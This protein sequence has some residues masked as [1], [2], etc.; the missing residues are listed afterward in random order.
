MNN[1]KLSQIK[2]TL[3]LELEEERKKVNNLIMRE[4]K[5]AH[6]EWETLMKVAHDDILK[7]E[8]HSNEECLA[9]DE[10]VETLRREV[11]DRLSE[12][13]KEIDDQLKRMRDELEGRWEDRKG[14][15]MS[16]IL[17]K[18]REAAEQKRLVEEAAEQKKK[19]VNEKL[20]MESEK[21]YERVRGAEHSARSEWKER[22]SAAV[23]NW[24][25]AEKKRKEEQ[26]LAQEEEA[27]M[28]KRRRD[29]ERREKRKGEDNQRQVAEQ[30]RR[31]ELAIDKAR[32]RIVEAWTQYESRWRKIKEQDTILSF[33][34]VPWPTLKVPK[35][36]LDIPIDEVRQLILS[37]DH[38]GGASAEERLRLECQRWHPDAFADILSR[39][40]ESD[41]MKVE[42][43][44]HLVMALLELLQESEGA[45]SM[46]GD[47]GSSIHT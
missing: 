27:E 24:L 3:E 43:G 10:K 15:E 34:S 38:S 32:T 25:E 41:R 37:P 22:M 17:E 45:A 14:V 9:E 2:Y 28:H 5:M 44:R 39:A 30:K 36:A 6:A 35:H 42:L 18:E 7:L 12:E 46:D 20:K 16:R 13:R 4:R 1:Q 21:L 29:Q 33:S 31:E 11:M 47:T 19:L 8:T 23:R 26:I 40:T